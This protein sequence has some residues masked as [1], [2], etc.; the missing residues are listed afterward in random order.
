MKG[1]DGR[2]AAF[3]IY[4][5]GY[6]GRKFSAFLSLLKE[7]GIEIVVDV[8]RFPRSK[9]EDYNREVL[10][11]N[12]GAQGIRYVFMGETLG[13]FR[14]GYEA[15]TKTETYRQGIEQLLDLLREG[16]VALMCL[17][18]NP[19]WCHRR[20]ICETLEEMGIQVEHII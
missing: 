2:S 17:E 16:R 4:T 14:G 20:Y 10:E 3:T 11:E 19:K 5:I 15:Y 18:R 6:G 13:G 1:S 7:H 9:D 12:L 8:R